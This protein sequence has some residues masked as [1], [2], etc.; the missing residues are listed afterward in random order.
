MSGTNPSIIERFPVE[1]W[2]EIFNYF[3][4]NDLWHSF[5]GLN[6]KINA[7]IEQTILHLNFEEQDSYYYFMKNML[8]ILNVVNVRSLKLQKP[9][10]VI[11]FFST[12][13]L[14]SL[15][16]LRF[17]SLNLIY[18]SGDSSLKP[19]NQLSSLKYLQSLNIM[20]CRSTGGRDNSNEEKVLIIHSIFNQN[21]CPL[22]KSLI[23]TTGELAH[24]TSLPSLIAIP[25][26]T[27]IEYLSIDA[28]YFE[29]LIKLLP[30]LRNVKSFHIDE[31]VYFN[32]MN[33]IRS[34]KMI[35]RTPLMPKCIRLHLNLEMG[36]TFNHIKYILKHTPNLQGLFLSIRPNLLN[37]KRWEKILSSKFPNLL[38]FELTCT[39]YMYGDYSAVVYERLETFERECQTPFWI[40]RNTTISYV[41]GYDHN[42]HIVRFHITKVS[43]I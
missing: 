29:D 14:S 12:F 9:I 21:F 27:I 15:I 6:R 26:M 35:F 1:L 28:L 23:I 20:L 39:D 3:N 43:F 32:D 34:R 5:H 18:S 31:G 19:W 41:Q 24:A 37:A 13:P 25:K 11:D 42:N 7:M 4:S 30:A 36:T 16:Q 8:P 38:K 22:L 2:L 10:E 33:D 17:L 40:E